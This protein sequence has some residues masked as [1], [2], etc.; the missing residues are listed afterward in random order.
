M[1]QWTKELIVEA[2][3][4][5]DGMKVGHAHNRAKRYMEKRLMRDLWRAWRD[6]LKMPAEREAA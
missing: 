5:N 6:D 4:D 3:E 2:R 1:T